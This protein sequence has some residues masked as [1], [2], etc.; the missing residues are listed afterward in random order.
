MISIPLSHAESSVQN[1]HGRP[2]SIRCVPAG[3]RLFVVRVCGRG[4]FSVQCAR[5]PV[6]MLSRH[7]LSRRTVCANTPAPVATE[8]AVVGTNGKATH[9]LRLV[10]R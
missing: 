10:R 2:M 3:V 1:D 6:E 9:S 5:T 7:R 8:H 4:I